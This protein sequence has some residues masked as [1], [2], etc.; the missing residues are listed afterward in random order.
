MMALTNVCDRSWAYMPKEINYALAIIIILCHTL[1]W[2]PDNYAK[3]VPKSQRPK[4]YAWLT[5]R[6]QQVTDTIT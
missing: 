3:Y 1:F 4:H 2:I 5:H 6:N